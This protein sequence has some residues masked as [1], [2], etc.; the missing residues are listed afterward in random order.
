MTCPSCAAVLVPGGRFCGECGVPVP[1]TN[2]QSASPPQVPGTRPV[3]PF[4]DFAAMGAAGVAIPGPGSSFAGPVIPAGPQLQTPN[5]APWEPGQADGAPGVLDGIL[6]RLPLRDLLPLHPWWTSGGW[7]QGG[8]ALFL[9]MALAPFVL[10]QITSDD[11]DVRRAAIGFAIYFAVLWLIA[12]HALVRP[13]RIGWPLFVGIVAFTTVAG[14]AFAI[15]VEKQLD[16]STDSLFS[17]IITVGFPEEVAKALVVLI[18]LRVNGGRWTPRTY[19]YAGALSGLAFGAAEAVTYTV[20]YSSSLGLGD[21]GL[22]VTLWR[23]L[24]DGLFHACMAGIVAFFIGLSAWY[25]TVRLQL[26]G[27]GLVVAGALHGLYDHWASGWGGAAIAAATVFTFVGYVRS[28]DRVST[29]LAEHLMAGDLAAGTH[30]A[31]WPGHPPMA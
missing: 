5:A 29:R 27:F 4:E 22:A 18:C 10:L 12:I 17:S 20:A 9:V 24:S 16:A 26:I 28:G 1:P 13:E 21:G 2:A 14:V 15:A 25:R 8:A 6:G 23:L 19:L 30:Q 7:R 3:P 31:G 11:T